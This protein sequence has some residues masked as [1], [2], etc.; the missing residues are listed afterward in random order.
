MW[1]NILFCITIIVLVLFFCYNIKMLK[2]SHFK[3]ATGFLIWA[4]ISGNLFFL[5]HTWGGIH[6]YG[7]YPREV[8]MYWLAYPEYNIPIQFGLL[9]LAFLLVPYKTFRFRSILGM[10]FIFILTL[11]FQIK[12]LY[13]QLPINTPHE[14]LNAFYQ[15]QHAAFM[16]S[17]F[18]FLF[19]LIDVAVN[20]FQTHKERGTSR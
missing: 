4:S 9:A 19:I 18:I 1:V 6:V 2:G 20:F 5:W 16:G 15:A 14:H 10:N 12:I 3:A 13:N 8:M 7:L 17:I 11:A